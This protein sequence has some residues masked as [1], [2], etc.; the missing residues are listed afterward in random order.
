MVELLPSRNRNG[1]AVDLVASENCRV[2]HEGVRVTINDLDLEGRIREVLS[3]AGR[4]DMLTR[5]GR[6]PELFCALTL[7]H[8]A[9]EAAMNRLNTMRREQVPLDVA[10]VYSK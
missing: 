1:A 7:I 4:L 3:N 5:E 10:A 2:L 8:A 6:E 9:S